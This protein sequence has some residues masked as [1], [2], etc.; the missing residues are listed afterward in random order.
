MSED[1]WISTKERL[2]DNNDSYL[3]VYYTTLI[4]NGTIRDDYVVSVLWYRGTVWIDESGHYIN[5]K[6][7]KYWEPL[8]ALPEELRCKE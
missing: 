7:V 5:N 6:N 4:G 1:K 8:P 3:A 2:P